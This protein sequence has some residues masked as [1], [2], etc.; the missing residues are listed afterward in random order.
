MDE[1]R[2]DALSRSFTVL[3][4]RRVLV[5][6]ELTRLV[7][8]LALGGLVAALGLR[9]TPAKRKKKS[10]KK[11]GSTAAT[12]TPNCGNR[13]CGG[14]G[15]GGSCGVCGA[16][17]GCVEGSCLCLSGFKPCQGGCIPLEQCC[18]SNCDDGNPCTT[19]A[20]N[21][22][23]CAQT[24]VADGTLCLNAEDQ[25]C[26]GGVC[27]TPP[28]CCTPNIGGCPGDFPCC[29]GGTPPDACTCSG[30]GQPCF[31]SGDCCP[32]TCVGFVCTA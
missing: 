15:C 4:A 14:N 13:T 19:G 30:L 31:E 9:E 24:P 23:T 21:A 16:G 18:P 5:R 3:D 7:G 1:L 27:A 29:A 25:V 2:F 11:R 28:V 12:C 22:G 10:K 20:C 26:S 6:R 8:G 32:G 17:A